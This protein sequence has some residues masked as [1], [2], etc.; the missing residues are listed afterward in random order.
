MW[1]DSRQDVEA[2]AKLSEFFEARK[3]A[4]ERAGH[5]LRKFKAAKHKS[6]DAKNK[7]SEA[8]ELLKRKQRELAAERE[9]S[10]RTDEQLK[11]L[12]FF[13]AYML[14]QGLERGGTGHHLKERNDFLERVKAKFPP[15]SPYHENNWREFKKRF[16]HIHCRI[17]G[18]HGTAYGTWFHREMQRLIQERRDGHADAL[19]KW[20]DYHIDGQS[21]FKNFQGI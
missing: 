3:I 13:D 15:L 9:E 6:Q 16:E 14:G 17:Q 7:A 5:L 19:Q 10:Q 2:S 1:T 20:M 18:Y 4:N 8:V 12:K 21:M 11:A